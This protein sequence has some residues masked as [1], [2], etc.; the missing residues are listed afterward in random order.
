MKINNVYPI[1]DVIEAAKYYIQQ[2]NRR[3]TF[4]YILLDGI[5]DEIRHA[6]ELSDLIRGMNAYVNLIRYNPVDEFS[7][8]ASSEETARAFHH[9]LMDRGITATLRHEKGGDIDAACGQLRA[10]KLTKLD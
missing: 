10:K 1:K 8:Q 7:Y 9:R 4:E 3:I 2:T 6:D 5:N